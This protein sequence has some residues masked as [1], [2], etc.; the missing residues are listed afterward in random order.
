[1]SEKIEHANR[2]HALLSASGA[3]RWLNCTPSARL[4]EQYGEHKTSPYAQEGTLAHEL[5]ELYLRRDVLRGTSEDEFNAKLEEIMSNP[6]FQDE[7][8]EM[9]PIYTDYCVS[10]L[11]EARKDNVFAVMEIEQKLDFSE[12]VPEGFGTADCC[13]VNDNTLEVIDLKY[14][15][16]VPVYA[17]WNPQ[18]M[19]YGI[20][21][22]RKYCMVYD[23]ENIRLTIIQPRLDNISTFTLTVKELQDWADEILEPAAQSAFN[24][25]G[26]LNVGGWCRF[27]SVK[28]RCRRLAQEQLELAKHEFRDAPLLT[29]EEIADIISKAPRLMEWANSIVEYAQEQAVNHGKHWPGYKLVEEVSRR[30]WIDENKVADIIMQTIPAVSE[31]QLYTTKLKSITEV[32]KLLGRRAFTAIADSVCVKPEGK[33]TLVPLDDKRPAIGN[34]QAKI[35]FAE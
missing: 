22:W 23:I 20:G 6:L 9:V 28:N 32:E 13:I 14:G 16:G 11:I 34:E 29:D 26:D 21:A 12:Y 3:S 17:D 1:M 7:M 10:Q 31:D 19:I 25:K 8:L 2:A 35:D 18:L 15:K 30:R 24:G 4:E 33:P 27:C 5:A